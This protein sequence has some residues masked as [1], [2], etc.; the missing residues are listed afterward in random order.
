MY[1]YLLIGLG[2]AVGAILRAMLS[3]VFSANVWGVPLPILGINILG[4]C[5]AGMVLALLGNVADI[6]TFVLTGVLGGFTTFSA[7]S[8]ETMHL[9]ETKQYKIALLYVGLSVVLSCAGAMFGSR[10]ASCVR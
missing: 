10:L 2:G 6:K 9:V 8:L 3:G 5:L 7:F 1:S 4:C